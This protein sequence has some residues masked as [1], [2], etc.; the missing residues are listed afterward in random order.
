MSSKNDFQELHCD[1][2]STSTR[3]GR[4]KSPTVVRGG[5]RAETVRHGGSTGS[6]GDLVPELVA[7]TSLRLSVATHAVDLENLSGKDVD[8]TH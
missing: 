4:T 3:H 5:L 7:R 2:V 6:T 1:D 8:V